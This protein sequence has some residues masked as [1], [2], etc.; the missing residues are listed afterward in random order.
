V[1]GAWHWRLIGTRTRIVSGSVPMDCACAKMELADSMTD[2]AFTLR[3]IGFPR[4]RPLLRMAHFGRK[5][6]ELVVESL[7]LTA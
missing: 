7:V 4:Q 6:Q 3:F 1:N 2:A 5:L